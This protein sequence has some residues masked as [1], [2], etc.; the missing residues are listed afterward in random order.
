MYDRLL[1]NSKCSCNCTSVSSSL[2]SITY[3]SVPLSS[4]CLFRVSCL[5]SFVICACRLYCWLR[6]LVNNKWTELAW[7]LPYTI[8]TA[9]INFCKQLTTFL[10]ILYILYSYVGQK[11]K[12]SLPT[13]NFK[14]LS[15]MFHYLSSSH[16]ELNRV[17]TDFIQSPF[18]CI[19]FWKMIPK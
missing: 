10:R 4:L 6:T 5:L 14:C 15:L 12:I 2:L 9:F 1:I 3:L 7:I 13:P 8:F 16:R 17:N 18:S 19:T 11:L